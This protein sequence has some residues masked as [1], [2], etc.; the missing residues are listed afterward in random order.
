MLLGT[1]P[2]A[3]SQALGTACNNHRQLRAEMRR[4]IARGEFS[5]VYQPRIDL[6]TGAVLGCEALLRWPGRRRG[7]LAPSAFIPAA[8][9]SELISELG[10][11]LLKHACTEAQLW[12]GRQVSVNVWSRQLASGALPSQVAEA[13]ECS[14]L[15]PDR[16]EL[17]FS[18]SVLIECGTETLLTLSALRDLG[19]GLALADF[20]TGWASIGMLKR[21]PLTTL[22]L[23]RSMVCELPGNHEDA[24]IVRA[25]IGAGR[26]LGLTVV[27]DGIETELQRAYLANIGCDGGQGCLFGRPLSPELVWPLVAYRD[28]TCSARRSTP[29]TPHGP[30]APH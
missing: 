4:G 7:A 12:A 13:L 2:S 29:E 10:A 16:L 8:E 15:Q 17:E 6:P 22:K 19:L 5:V 21:L 23:A 1:S 25:M 18:E 14:G 24:A 27:A 26:A 28:D 30:A 3:S 9:G 20:G 11:W